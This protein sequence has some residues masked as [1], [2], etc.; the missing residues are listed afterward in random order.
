MRHFLLAMMTVAL[1]AGCK[2]GD[3]PA[4]APAPAPAPKP[5]TKQAENKPTYIPAGIFDAPALPAT[6]TAPPAEPAP[7]SV[8]DKSIVESVAA[9]LDR[10]SA[11]LQKSS[12]QIASRLGKLDQ[13]MAGMQTHIEDHMD[14]LAAVSATRKPQ[15][16]LEIKPAVPQAAKALIDKPQPAKSLYGDYTG[17]AVWI[18]EDTKECPHCGDAL[19]GL[20]SKAASCNFTVGETPDA[21]WWIRKAP[22]SVAKDGLPLFVYLSHGKVLKKH[23]GYKRQDLLSIIYAHPQA[24]APGQTKPYRATTVSMSVKASNAIYQTQPPKAPAAAELGESADAPKSEFQPVPKADWDD[25]NGKTDVVD[26]VPAPSPQPNCSRPRSASCGA[27]QS[28]S[29]RSSG[30]CGGGSVTY[31]IRPTYSDEPSC[32]QPKYYYPAT[33]SDCSGSSAAMSY[34]YAM[35]RQPVTYSYGGPWDDNGGGGSPS[36]SPSCSSPASYGYGGGYGGG[37]APQNYSYSPMSYGYGGGSNC[38]GGVCYPNYGYMH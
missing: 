24:E 32:S 2:P 29:Y 12:D 3:N 27:P 25:P 35:P 16:L 11:S 14:H 37:Y 1:M 22:K 6:V 21:H 18:S 34:V 17:C 38:P 20:N 7:A 28:R 13:T 19:V 36:P 8:S 5:I 31:M 10:Q 30:D 15:P 4:P 9:A 23:L 33:S 26:P